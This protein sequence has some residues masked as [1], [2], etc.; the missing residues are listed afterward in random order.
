MENQDQIKDKKNKKQNKRHYGG[1]GH[2]SIWQEKRDKKRQRLANEED[3]KQRELRGEDKRDRITYT[4]NEYT[5]GNVKFDEYYRKQ[6]E[7]IITTEEEFTEFKNTL[8]EK[9]PVT[10]RA[11]P[12]LINYEKIVEMF[13]DPSF[14][15]NNFE[16]I[17]DT[18]D[19]EIKMGQADHMYSNHLKKIKID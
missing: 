1:G 18:N 12:G 8:Y 13:K 11:N 6:F 17:E 7:G 19:K 2:A 10:F 15:E 4:L 9:L 14:I 3:D 16:Y 5:I